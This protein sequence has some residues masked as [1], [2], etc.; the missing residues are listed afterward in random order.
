MFKSPKE[1]GDAL[2][3]SRYQYEAEAEDLQGRQE[4][5][6]KSYGKAAE[7]MIAKRYDETETKFSEVITLIANELLEVMPAETR[8]QF[9]DHFY[10]ST[11]DTR[12][13]NASIVRSKEGY[14]A[15][16]I[17]SSL[18]AL[19]TKIGKLEIAFRNPRCV[20]FCSRTPQG[21]PTKD[22]IA[23][24][25]AESYRYF[26]EHKMS[27]GPFLVIGGP[28]ALFHFDRLD[29]QEKLILF[30]EI[31][32]FICGDLYDNKNER[33]FVK[34][35][36]IKNIRYQSELF[37]D[38]IGF[39]LLLRLEKRKGEISLGR[40]LVILNALVF[41][42]ELLSRLQV[43]ETEKYP[44]PLNRM[45]T[46]IEYYYGVEIAEVVE[47]ILKGLPGWTWENLHPD[48]CPE[49]KSNEVLMDQLITKLLKSAF[50]QNK[51]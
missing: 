4:A 44:H 47:K 10:F 51:S 18:I 19:L 29:I 11:A 1:F 34:S 48:T 15:V 49:I 12:S 38:I 5:L 16:I 36:N 41:L 33:V 37:A 25:R 23:S 35:D 22:E 30:H 26:A 40:R 20:E 27:H 42:F 6:R 46:L 7:R 21:K 14:F 24:M 13:I 8:T 2:K 17:N 3:R 32:H 28:E 39:G 50:D 45:N 9:I 31:G 43:G